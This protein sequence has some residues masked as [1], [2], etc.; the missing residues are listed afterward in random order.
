MAQISIDAFRDLY[1]EFRGPVPTI[2]SALTPEHRLVHGD[3]E[4]V[5]L[6][7]WVKGRV[8]LLGDAAHATTPNMGQGAAMAIEDA[9]VLAEELAKPQPVEEALAAYQSR[10]MPRVQEIQQRSW[11]FGRLAQ[12]ESALIG[13]V[14][15]TVVRLVP[16][17]RAMR[18]LERLL[19]KPI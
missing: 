14:R 19:S 5:R 9:Y 12:S 3:L 6:S 7:A 10:R 16:A 1:R 18:G 8:V 15:N 17:S 13:F 11:N 2:L 4:E